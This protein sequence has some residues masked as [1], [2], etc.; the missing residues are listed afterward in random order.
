MI[1][2][3]RGAK[4]GRRSGGDQFLA[5]DKPFLLQA[6]GC[7]G[8]PSLGPV[9]QAAPLQLIGPEKPCI[10]LP[11][12]RAESLSS[13]GRYRYLARADEK[14]TK[15][16]DQRERT[17]SSKDREN[18]EHRKHYQQ[19]DQAT[20]PGQGHQWDSEYATRARAL[21]HIAQSIWED[22]ASKAHKDIGDHL[23]H[24]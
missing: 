18:D 10:H 4:S 14:D 17:G 22:Y 12:T 15:G 1:A 23:G 20:Q 11:A 21:I 19:E 5:V 6:H 3:D 13:P 8:S 2:I 24:Q 7:R 9:S 16:H